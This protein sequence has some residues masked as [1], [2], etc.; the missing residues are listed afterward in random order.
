MKSFFL[1]GAQSREAVVEALCDLLPGQAEPWLLM[2]GVGDPVAYLHLDD[3]GTV[4]ADLSGR[5][6]DKGLPLGLLASLRERVG[7]TITD[8]D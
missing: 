5:H 3:K 1:E 8:D 7:G 2:V 6:A 4:Q